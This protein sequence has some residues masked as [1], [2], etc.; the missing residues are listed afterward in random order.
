[1]CAVGLAVRLLFAT[2]VVPHLERRANVAPDPDRYADLAGSLL[3]RGELGFS[4]PGASPTSLRGPAFPSW[5][6]VGMLLGGR[7]SRWVSLWASVPGLL[8]AAAVFIALHRSHGQRAALVGGLLCAAHPLSCF[9]SARVLPDEFYGALLLLG[10]LAVGD[11]PLF[12][13][14]LPGYRFDKKK[15]SVL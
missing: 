1:V 7:S 14:K 10:L 12:L 2:V 4:P 13:T 3:D 9:V 15:G 8:A 6:A 11:T 5:L